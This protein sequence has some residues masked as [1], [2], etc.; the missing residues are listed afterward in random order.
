[1]SWLRSQRITGKE[2]SMEIDYGFRR[3]MGKRVYEFRDS[4]GYRQAKFADS[5]D[6]SVTFLSEVEN[7]RKGMSIDTLYRLCTRYRISS[8][9]FV[10]GVPFESDPKSKTIIEMANKMPNRE[11]NILINYLEA[12]KNMRDIDKNHYPNDGRD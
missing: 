3:A 7:G 2:D 11:L 8:D 10:L 5:L 1:M 4:L 9:Y 12:L 6:I